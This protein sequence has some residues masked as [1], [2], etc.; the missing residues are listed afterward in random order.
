MEYVV[1]VRAGTALIVP[2][3]VCPVA[4]QIY[5]R[6]LIVI[7]RSGLAPYSRNT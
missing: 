4:A 6:A 2:N 1:V 7:A 3:V 5:A